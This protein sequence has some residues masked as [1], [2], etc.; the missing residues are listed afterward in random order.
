MVLDSIGKSSAFDL[1]LVLKL[2]KEAA[3]EAG[4]R[5]VAMRR[6]N[7]FEVSFKSGFDPVTTADLEAEEII[8][9][10]ILKTFPDHKI[11]A[12]ESYQGFKERADYLM[13]LWIIDPI[14][15]TT[16][17][18]LGHHQ[19]A[20]SIAFA[21]HGTVLV[22]VVHA[23]FQN[24]T[25]WAKRG[26]GA[27]LNNQLIRPSGTSDLA[28]ALIGFGQPSKSQNS[29][30]FAAIY[31]AVL[32]R[33]RDMRRIGA[34]AL[35]IS[36]V[37]PGRYDAFYETLKP[38]DMAAACLIAREAGATVGHLEPKSA[39]EIIP[40]DLNPRELVVATPQIYTEF[41]ELLRVRY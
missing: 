41:C 38:W 5:I 19:V 34:G 26:G 29:K 33:C 15:G 3:L 4:R 17:Y 10:R 11:M 7:D 39:D 8:I 40:D 28:G 16:N 30:R 31:E 14:D 12:E 37:A 1:E 6:S 13:P 25:F 22:G 2:T 9:S 35:D 18:T 20:V 23:P 36:W 21:H 32:D 27:F 24:E